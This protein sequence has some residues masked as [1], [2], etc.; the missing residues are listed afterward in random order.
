[1]YIAKFIRVGAWLLV[2]L[3][4]LMAFGVIGLFTRMSPAIAVIIERNERSLQASAGMLAILAEAGDA[5]FT[6]EMR[7]RFRQTLEDAGANTTE[8]GEPETLARIRQTAPAALAGDAAAKK[9]LIGEINRLYI[10]NVKAMSDADRRA[11]HLGRAGAWGVVVMATLVFVAGLVFIRNFTRRIAAPLEELHDVVLAHGRGD[12]LRR[13]GGVGG[14]GVSRDFH[15]IFTGLNAILDE[16]TCW[17]RGRQDAADGA[18]P[19]Q[20]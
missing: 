13:C 12:L 8:S 9:E 14:E 19:P 2:G 15:A 6:D 11:Q 4:L 10:I 17:T 3:N 5:P 1:M 18:P 20:G 16:R 7:G